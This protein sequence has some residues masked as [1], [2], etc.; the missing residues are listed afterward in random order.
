MSRDWDAPRVGRG[1][2]VTVFRPLLAEA[3]VFSSFPAVL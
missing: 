1:V 3:S 2:S